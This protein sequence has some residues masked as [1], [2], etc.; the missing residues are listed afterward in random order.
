M[1]S[2]FQTKSCVVL[3]NVNKTKF[4]LKFISYGDIQVALPVSRLYIYIKLEYIVNA[5]AYLSCG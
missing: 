4:Y 2:Y 1:Y 5:H 3:E